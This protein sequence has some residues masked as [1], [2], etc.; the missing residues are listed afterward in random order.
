M[1]FYI[2]YDDFYNIFDSIENDENDKRKADYIVQSIWVLLL[3]I[4]KMIFING[5][6]H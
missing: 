2:K 5:L 1:R 6:N 4:L 3:D